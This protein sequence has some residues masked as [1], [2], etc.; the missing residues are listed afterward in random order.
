[1]WLLAKGKHSK[2]HKNLSRLRGKVSYDKCENEFQEMII[3]NM[4]SNNDEPRNFINLLHRLFC[5][6]L[7]NSK[8]NKS[9]HFYSPQ[10]KYKY[11][12]TI[13]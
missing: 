8:F 4:P 1:M 12:E 6:I 3:Y 13:F 7:L 5:S 2:A 11:M 9:S 10:R